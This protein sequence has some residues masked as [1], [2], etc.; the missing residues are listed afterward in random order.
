MIDGFGRKI[1]YLRIS[2]TDRCNLRCR[3][4]M[5]GD[6]EALPAGSILSYEE[7]Q[8]VVIQAVPLG[9]RK[10]KVTGG[11][12]LVRKGCIDFLTSL[13]KIPGIEQVTLTTNGLLLRELPVLSAA[14]LDGINISLDTLDRER[15]R[16]LSGF[17]ALDNVLASIG[18][19]VDSGIL[20]KL[21]AVSVD[22]SKFGLLEKGNRFED[23]RALTEFT[24]NQ[25][26]IVRFIEVMPVGF[27]RVFPGIAHEELFSWL[28]SHY[29]NIEKDPTVYGNGPAVY[30]Q[31]P[32]Y[33]GRIGLI[34]AICG[35]FCAQCNRLRL[36]TDGYLKSC[37]S[38]DTGVDLKKIL[39]SGGREDDINQGLREGITLAIRRKPE[40]HSFLDEEKMTEKKTMSAIGG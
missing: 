11:E 27:G 12:P 26:I 34:S 30:Y 22:F 2:I 14:G 1:D 28:I 16:F 6:I 36:T 13:K 35:N 25:N 32:G 20:V 5:P 3:Y 15:Y 23:I 29:P 9:I 18:A 31:I 19:A 8:K 39:R 33:Q 21:N 38:Y 7:I 17:D 37:L 10:I 4:C 40:F 24:K